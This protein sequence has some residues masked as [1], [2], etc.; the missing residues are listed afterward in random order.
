MKLAILIPA[1]NEEKTIGQVIDSIPKHLPNIEN[2]QI[3][4]V[5]DGSTDNTSKIAKEK[6]ALL[7]KH[8]K[9]KG[10]GKSFQDGLAKALEIKADILVNI[11]A[12]GQ[13]DTSEIEKLIQPIAK[14]EADLVTGSR[15][16]D[17]S[18]IPKN[19]PWIKRWGNNRV[20]NI[21]SWATGQKFHD[22]SC[23]FRAYGKEAM[24]RLNLFG[25][26]TYTQETFLDLAYKGLHIMEVPVTVRYFKERKS[27]VAHSI[28]G[29]ATKS[30]NIIFRTIKDYRPLKFFGWSGAIIF[31]FGLGLDIFVF[32]HFL[33]NGTFTPY[34]IFGFM[35]A[36]L[37]AIGIMILFIGVLA[38]LIDKV[39]LTQEKILYHEKKRQYDKES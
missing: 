23:G 27:R 17:K 3:I 24:L 29:Y 18:Y 13:F 25:S 31:L 26:F 34:K 7:I 14:K 16:I 35:G 37:N 6:G 2:I 20:A 38:D 1:L 9:N 12:D 32:N 30:A 11:D 33:Q 36:F 39:R 10:V 28:F 19:M 5:D 22:V 4:V 8:K 21:I 15:F